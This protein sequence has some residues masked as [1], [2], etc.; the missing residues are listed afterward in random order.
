MARG[1]APAYL[2]RGGSGAEPAS[3]GPASTCRCTRPGGARDL[4]AHATC[5]RTRGQEPG[6]GPAHPS[7]GAGPGCVR[8][9]VILEFPTGGG[10]AG[11]RSRL[12]RHGEEVARVRGVGPPSPCG[13]RGRVRRRAR[14]GRSSIGACGVRE[15]AIGI[16][17]G[18]ADQPQRVR[19]PCGAATRSGR[20]CPGVRGPGDGAGRRSPLRGGV[21]GRRIPPADP[22]VAGWRPGRPAGPRRAGRRSPR[23]R[24]ARAR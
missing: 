23:S 16:L 1:G 18:T 4:Q 3:T 24:A 7:A 15:P 21:T 10:T 19:G 2:H 17:P 8:K 14:P 13:C 20:T 5:R 11:R 6:R 22:A 12:I 9:I